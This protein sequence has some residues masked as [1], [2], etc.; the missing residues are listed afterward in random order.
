MIVTYSSHYSVKVQEYDKIVAWCDCE[1][2][3]G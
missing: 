2:G 1:I 3:K